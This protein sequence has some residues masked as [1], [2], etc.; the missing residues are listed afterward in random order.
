MARH[1]ERAARLRR[2]YLV[3][4]AIGKSA[5]RIENL[6]AR[7]GGRKAVTGGAR[8][9][10]ALPDGFALK[11]GGVAIGASR[12][13]LLAA[14]DVNQVKLL[15]G[16]ELR[17]RARQFPTHPFGGRNAIIQLPKAVNDR[18]SERASVWRFQRLPRKRRN[19]TAA[20][21]MA[22]GAGDIGD[23]RRPEIASVVFGVTRG[24]GQAD[25]HMFA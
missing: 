18:I 16:I 25:F 15:F 14:C 5:A 9:A 4:R 3:L 23:E 7:L 8:F 2:S 24:A 19:E 22:S 21:A 11:S 12:P 6:R 13:A 10:H 20:I 17:S 1:T